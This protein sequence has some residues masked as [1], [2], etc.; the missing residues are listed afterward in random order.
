[1]A[2]AH[3]VAAIVEDAAGQNGRRAPEPDLPR[4]GV[5]GELGL[6]GLEQVAVENRLVLATMHLA[7]IDDLANVESVLE[8]VGERSNAETDT[9]P[10]API[11]TAICLGPDAAPIKV[12]DQ[13]GQRP[14]RAE[15]TRLVPAAQ[16]LIY[17][18]KPRTI[19]EF[20][21]RALVRQ[22][23]EAGATIVMACAV[24]DTLV[25]GTL[26]LQVRGGQV[27]EKSL[28]HAIR[29][30]RGRTFEQD[31]KYPI[32]LLVDIAIR[33][34]SPA[35][36]DPTTAVQ[37][38]DQ[39]EDLLR[40]LGSHALDTGY[41]ADTDGVVRLVYPMPTWEDY[42][43]LAFDEIR[44]YGSTSVQVL[45]RLRSALVDLAAYLSGT[46][47]ADAVRHYLEQLDLDIDHSPL[48]AEDRLRARQ[49]DR[50]GLGL[51]RRAVQVS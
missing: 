41:A 16:T 6:H 8:Q 44:Q 25:E 40:R 45:R 43:T 19:A 17:S 35:I 26:L 3:P 1:V 49:E 51:S 5:G 18:G 15:R 48:D 31:P 47:R 46:E 13:G 50:Q 30:E 29:L 32:R 38:I 12:L 2:R 4:D 34:L 21:V 14:K 24:G 22:A 33:A 9:A 11:G 37:T 20:D 7:P 39:I 28:L 42:L 23:R 36:N 27:P 10:P